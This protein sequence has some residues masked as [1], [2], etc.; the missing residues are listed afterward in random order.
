[1]PKPHLSFSADGAARATDAAPIIAGPSRVRYSKG[2]KVPELDARPYERTMSK[3]E[4]AV[5]GVSL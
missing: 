1:M 5:V 3:R 2:E 4:K